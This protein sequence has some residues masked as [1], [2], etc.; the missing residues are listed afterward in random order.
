MPLN[1]RRIWTD[2]ELEADR[3]KAIS[4]FRDERLKESLEDY[5]D[6]FEEAQASTEDLLEATVDLTQFDE[7]LEILTNDG[8]LDSFRYLAGPPIST[9]DLKVLADSD[10]L[11][12]K[13]LQRDPERVQRLL[14]TVMAGLDRRRFAW[15]GEKRDPSPDERSAAILATAAVMATQRVGTQRRTEGS[16]LQEESVQQALIEHGFRLVSRRDVLTFSLAPDPGEFCREALVGTRKADIIRL[17]DGR[18]MPTEC[19]VSNSATNSIKRLNNDAAVKARVWLEE[20]GTRQVVP[21]AVISGVF[22]LGHL[23]SAQEAGLSLFWSHSL[24]QM[25]YWIEGTRG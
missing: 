3:Q 4:I 15:L 23:S 8:L 2:E 22:K 10:S 6:A 12:R 14:Q 5:L 21:A 13:T 7:A 17:W 25:L 20:F 1:N 9:D 24:N 19:K 18:L 11:A 16:Q